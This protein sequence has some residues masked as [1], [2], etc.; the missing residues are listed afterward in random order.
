MEMAK[1]HPAPMEVAKRHPAPTEV[2]KRHPAP[3][4]VAKKDPA[5]NQEICLEAQVTISL[6]V[7][8][9]DPSLIG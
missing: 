5:Q 6:K 1:R 9:L 2:A 4:E 3:M 7:F 8:H